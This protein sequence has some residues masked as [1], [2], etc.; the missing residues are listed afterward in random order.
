MGIQC[1]VFFIN[2]K[3]NGKKAYLEA[4]F[5]LRKL[6][7]MNSYDVIHCHHVFSALVL[8]LTSFNFR[9]ICIISYQ[10]SPRYEGGLLLFHLLKLITYKIIIK[11]NNISKKYKNTFHLPNGVDT[12]LFYHRNRNDCL[13]ILKLDKN[14]NYILFVDS[15]TKSRTQ[16]RH[17]RFKHT[18]NILK[19]DYKYNNLEPIV[20]TNVKRNLM[21]IY[22]NAVNVYLLTSDFEGSPN[23]V[24]EC[25]A[26]GTPVVSTNVGN[27]SDILMNVP[28]SYV[29]EEFNANL[30]A[31]KV[32]CVLKNGNISK[33]EVKLENKYNIIHVADVLIKLY[34]KCIQQNKKT[35]L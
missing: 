3:E 12:N 32:D 2:G 31:E 25:V 18:L 19:R 15:N 23:T 5:E 6:L 8:L 16:K 22:I 33:N 21:P 34:K 30:L 10:N 1:D 35:L 9:K 29:V 17:D 7:C 26:C 28:G 24:K 20:L 27:V 4:I 13:N 14:K 11:N